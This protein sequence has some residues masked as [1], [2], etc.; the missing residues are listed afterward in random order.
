MTDLEKANNEIICRQI[1][2]DFRGKLKWK[3]DDRMGTLLAEFN[4]D[5]EDD[6]RNILDRHLPFTWDSSNIKTAPRA[7]QSL[8][9]RLGGLWANQYLFISDLPDEAL[10][11]SAWWPWDN[12]NTISLRIAPFSKNFEH[13]EK[14]DFKKQLMAFAEV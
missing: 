10:V 14:E 8:S 7:V 2:D 12:G 9:E 3:W 13:P 6:V 11:F 4:T 1:L 5:K